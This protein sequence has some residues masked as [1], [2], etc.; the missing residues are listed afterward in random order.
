MEYQSKVDAVEAL[1]GKFKQCPLAI[2]TDYRGLTVAEIT[3]LRRE[4]GAVDGEFL[5][6]KNTLTKLALHDTDFTAMEPLL[7]GPTAI[8]FAYSDPVALAKVVN[9][10]AAKNDTLELKGGVMEGELLDAGRIKQLAALPS[11]DELRAKLLALLMT[12]ATQLV[13][14]LNAP[15]QQ[16]V[17][18]LEARRSSQ[19]S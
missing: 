10:F 2:L 3:D 5:V 8:A 6:A 11:R 19:E 1:N 17:Q 9:G 13:R 16:M 7:S 4:V 14:V 18:V 12:P 15:A